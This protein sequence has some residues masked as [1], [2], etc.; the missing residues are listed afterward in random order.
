MASSS[1]VITTAFSLP[2]GIRSFNKS[3]ALCRICRAD[4]W[5]FALA[6]SGA[7]WNANLFSMSLGSITVTPSEFVSSFVDVDRNCLDNIPLAYRIWTLVWA[8]HFLKNRQETALSRFRWLNLR[9]VPEVTHEREEVFLC[10]KQMVVF[11]V[12]L[13]QWVLSVIKP[14]AGVGFPGKLLK[15][16]VVLWALLSNFPERPLGHRINSQVG[17]HPVDSN[18]FVLGNPFYSDDDVVHSILE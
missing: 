5:S 8:L 18:R 17:I 1:F 14:R 16:P 6:S 7:E 10:I 9:H 2:S 15:F 4:V 12:Y 3:A 11:V 13:L